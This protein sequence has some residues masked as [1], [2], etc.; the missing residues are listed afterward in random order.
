MPLFLGIFYLVRRHPGGGGQVSYTFPLRITCKKG[1]G[2]GVQIA[3]KIAYVL[4]GRPLTTKCLLQF[5]TCFDIDLS[6]S[7]AIAVN[8]NKDLGFE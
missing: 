2:E 5:K 1:G 8:E 7:Q 4:N 3:C 6:L